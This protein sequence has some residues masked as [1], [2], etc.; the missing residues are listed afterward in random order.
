M[1]GALEMKKIFGLLMCLCLIFCLVGCNEKNEEEKKIV[2]IDLEYY[3]KY[4]KIPE[5]EY[6]IG[7]DVE[8]LKGIFESK[9]DEEHS[10]DEE[11]HDHDG[12][13]YSLMENDE[14]ISL[15]TGNTEYIYKEENEEKGISCIVTY[16][17]AYET[18]HGTVISKVEEAFSAFEVVREEN[19]D[20][21]IF[22]MAGGEFSFLKYS[23][24][25]NDII[26]VFADNALCATAIYDNTQWEI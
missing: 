7:Q 20:D 15:H 3:S 25:K 13:Y 10:E 18:A 14:Y 12:F 19:A 21:G 23:F 5:C 24:E 17:D 16:A 22:F 9:M 8:E 2:G 1:K 11:T 4:G 6:V 26:F